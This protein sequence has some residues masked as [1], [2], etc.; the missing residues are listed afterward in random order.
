MNG[1]GISLS[2]HQLE[3]QL[4]GTGQAEKVSA[5]F[6]E[7]NSM[8]ILEPKKSTNFTGH[9]RHSRYIICAYFFPKEKHVSLLKCRY[10]FG[11]N[12]KWNLL[13]KQINRT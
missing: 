7:G 4:H 1:T 13:F 2:I 11:L 10:Q 6:E 8:N 3:F 9:L 12:L 5:F